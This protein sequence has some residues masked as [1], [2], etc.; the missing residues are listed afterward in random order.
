MLEA[1]DSSGTLVPIHQTTWITSLPYACPTLTIY[2]FYLFTFKLIKKVGKPSGYRTSLN[3]F[4]VYTNQ[5]LSTT[6]DYNEYIIKYIYI[7]VT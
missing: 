5:L 4:N 2:L 6:K 7:R 3:E 1:A